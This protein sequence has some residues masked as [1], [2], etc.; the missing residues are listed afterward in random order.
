MKLL[1]WDIDGTLIWTGGA[2]ERAL[3]TSMLDNFGVEANMEEI[4]YSGRTDPMIARIL[5]DRY[6]VEKSEE[7]INRFLNGYLEALKEELPKGDPEHTRILPG[8]QNIL[9][10][11]ASDDGN[12]VQG[13][14]TGNLPQGAEIKL[15]FFELWHY[16]KFG[17][18]SDSHHIRNEL[19][20]IAVERARA[21]WGYDFDPQDIYVIGDSPH[22]VECGRFIGAKTIAVPTGRHDIYE[23]EE[24]NPDWL[25]ENF[26][27]PKRFFEAINES[28]S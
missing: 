23:L 9:D 19:A 5:F 24:M 4:D 21:L 18:F 22:D 14:L 8:I 2:G 11:I 25:F 10:E 17:A 6:K 27:N 7:N 15:S 28:A 13:L 12:F 1:L 3:T 26:A 20:P 16:F